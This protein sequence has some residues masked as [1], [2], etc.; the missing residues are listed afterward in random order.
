M[1]IATRN[2]SAV[3]ERCLAHYAD[4][5]YPDVEIVVGIN[6]STDGTEQML[7]EK[8]PHVK[9]VAFSENIGPLALNAAVE[10]SSGELLFRT[11]D[12][13]Y[14][15]AET[16]IADAVDFMQKFPD[17]IAISGEVIEA[18]IGYRLLDY[19]PFSKQADNPADGYPMYTFCGASSFVR[20][21]NFIEAGGFWDVFCHEE[22]EL[23]LRMLI[24]GGRIQYVP[25]IQTVH[26]S[27]TK[28]EGPEIFFHRWS[29]RYV[30]NIRLQW[31]YWPV[32]IALYRSTIISLF[33]VSVGFF[34][35]FPF[36]KVMSTA[37]HGFRT[38]R[39]G[40]R[41]RI[42]VPYKKLRAITMKR[43][44]WHAL[45]HHFYKRIERRRMTV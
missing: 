26:L 27:A 14:P 2:R 10:A 8:F 41:E 34:H 28:E 4:Q 6:G 42:P 13:A 21:K 31:K 25:W 5:T 39:Q 43:S 38:A 45:G 1:I 11:D 35:R 22:E 7:R 12:D 40:Y 37:L 32:L 9:I 17:V 33:M 20:R 15:A 16:T 29:I 36:T 24:K 19:Y 23:S 44:I 18:T 3:L 30:Y